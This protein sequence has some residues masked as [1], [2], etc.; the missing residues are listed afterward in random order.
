MDQ[1]SRIEGPE[2]NPHIQSIIFQ[3]CGQEYAIRKRE[4]LQQLVLGKLDSCMESN[5][6]R[7]H[8]HNIHKNKLKWL[9]ELSIRCDIIKLLK[10]NW[11]KFL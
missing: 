8:L 1:W 5:E 9:K 7:T 2:I 4:S 10:E 6:V 3:Q 11:Q